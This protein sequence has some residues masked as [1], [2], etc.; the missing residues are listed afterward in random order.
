[1]ERAA[2]YEPPLSVRGSAPA[3]WVPRFHQ[4]IA[5]GKNAAAAVTALKGTRL[6]PVLTRLPRWL[7]T[8]IAAARMRDRNPPADHVPA[9]DLVPT[10]RFDVQIAQEMADTTTEY[11]ALQA[12]GLLM[13]GTRSPHYVRTAIRE[14][15]AVIPRC[16]VV[17]LP[18]LGHSGPQNDGRPH[19]VARALRDFLTAP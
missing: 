4:E 6:D 17:T 11:S 18:G 10:M 15:A 5:A 7:L 19:A 8:P 12:R 1:M 3:A 13:A 16:Q 14:L 2:R 9:A